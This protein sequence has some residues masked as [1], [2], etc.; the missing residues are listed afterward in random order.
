MSELIVILAP[1]LSLIE[2]FKIRVENEIIVNF[3]SKSIFVE[4]GIGTDFSL[5]QTWLILSTLSQSL[6]Y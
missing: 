3:Y 4:C 6:F 2:E 5:I 1:F